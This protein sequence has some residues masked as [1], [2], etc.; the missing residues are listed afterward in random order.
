MPLHRRR[1]TP[2]RPL[3][4]TVIGIGAAVLTVA[5]LVLALRPWPDASPSRPSVDTPPPVQLAPAEDT[6]LAAP[7]FDLLVD[8]DDAA[9]LEDLAFYAWLDD[10]GAHED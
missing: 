5:A 4:R 9:M 7:D 1:R 6:P 8:G 2:R 3:A 10:S